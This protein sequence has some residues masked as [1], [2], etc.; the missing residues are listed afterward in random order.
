MR[1]I[2][3]DPLRAMSPTAIVSVVAVAISML[4]GCGGSGKAPTN[5]SQDPYGATRTNVVSRINELRASI[6]LP[7]LTQWTDGEACADEQAKADSES[8]QPHGAFGRCEE[9]AQNECPNWPN[10][11]SIASGCLQAMWNEGPGDDYSTHGHYI[12]MT[13]TSY[14]KV[15]VGFYTTPL[16]GVWAVMNFAP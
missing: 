10:A 14:H 1:G 9:T 16:G 15:A 11:E 8:G 3:S 4:C 12:N 6:G 2:R 7:A 13:N 5:P